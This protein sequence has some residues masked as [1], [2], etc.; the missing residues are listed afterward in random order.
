MSL[1]TPRDGRTSLI[2]ADAVTA[3][4]MKMLKDRNPG[5]GAPRV[6]S[7]LSSAHDG[8]RHVLEAADGSVFEKIVKLLDDDA[9]PTS[10]KT[11]RARRSEGAR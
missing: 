11:A 8:A 1:A 9:T 2:A 6:P 7:S 5:G 10:A 4:A 3:T